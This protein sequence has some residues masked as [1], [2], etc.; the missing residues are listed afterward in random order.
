VTAQQIADRLRK[1]RAGTR[2]ERRVL[3]ELARLVLSL[4]INTTTQEVIK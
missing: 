2:K 3:R 1:H 4:P